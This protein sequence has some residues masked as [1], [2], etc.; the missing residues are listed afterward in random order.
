MKPKKRINKTVWIALIVGV[1]FQVLFDPLSSLMH[2]SESVQARI[3]LPYARRKWEAQGI[4]HYKFDI[5]G[6]VPLVCIVGGSVEIENGVVVH[7]GPSTD[8]LTRGEPDLDLGFWPTASLP[9]CDYRNYTIP[10]FF[11]MVEQY[12]RSITQISF[13]PKYGF[14]SRFRLG[15]PGGYGLLSPRIFDCCSNFR[16]F[17]F[18]VLDE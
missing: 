15:S 12:S 18:I 7:T 17:N 9:L 10:I 4:T 5:R 2:L 13:D 1:A 16:V 8:A 6:Y 3:G 14:I 11:D